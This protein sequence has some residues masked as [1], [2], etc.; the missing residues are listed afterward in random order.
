MVNGK[1]KGIKTKCKYQVSGQFRIEDELCIGVVPLGEG[2]IKGG[3]GF[4]KAAALS[5]RQ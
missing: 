2:G 3:L 5:R 1:F 4:K